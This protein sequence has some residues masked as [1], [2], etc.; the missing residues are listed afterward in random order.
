MSKQTVPT[1]I[2]RGLNH[3]EILGEYL[4]GT[5]TNIKLP[6]RDIS[7]DAK[8]DI[9]NQSIQDARVTSTLSDPI[10]AVQ[11]KSYTKK[12]FTSG[13]FVT[14]KY[15]MEFI[16]VDNKSEA[17][18]KRPKKNDENDAKIKKLH[19]R[20]CLQ[21]IDGDFLVVPTHLTVNGDVQIYS[22]SHIVCHLCCAA[23]DLEY[24]VKIDPT[25]SL[26][27]DSMAYLKNISLMT[28]GSSKIRYAPS[29]DLHPNNGGPLSVED[30]YNGEATFRKTPNMIFA[31]NKMMFEEEVPVLREAP[32]GSRH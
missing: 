31:V 4:A 11:Y 28:T 30:Y 19:C 17:G 26:Y 8:E 20:H 21:S 18:S 10:F 23:S 16:K 22:G 5:Y 13:N 27:K 15:T 1:F 6:D 25:N 7:A 14:G 12:I 3:K 9:P 2:L 32:A 29:A 24:Q